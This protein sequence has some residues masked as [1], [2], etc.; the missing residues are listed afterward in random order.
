M[1]PGAGRSGQVIPNITDGYVGA[2]PDPGA[3]E[4]GRPAMQ[5]GVDAY[6]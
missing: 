2:A 1:N 4:Q 6:R 3:H 5:F